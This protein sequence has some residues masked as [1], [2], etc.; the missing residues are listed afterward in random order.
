MFDEI[1]KNPRWLIMKLT[2]K[3]K[4]HISIETAVE[5]VPL[6]IQMGLD[7]PLC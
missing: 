1:F 6:Y 3:A 5:S 7:E 2:Q 4:H